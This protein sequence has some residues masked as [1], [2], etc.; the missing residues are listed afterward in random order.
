M[1]KAEIEFDGLRFEADLSRPIDISIPV[2]R[3]ESP[4]AFHLSAPDYKTVEAGSFVGN[5]SRGG[6]CNCEDIIFNPHGN[7]THT[8]CAGHISKE[9]IFINDVLK[10]FFFPALLLSISPE[11]G[12]ITA[13]KIKNAWWE[14]EIKYEAVI[15]RTLP[16]TIDK[17]S[18]NYS[19]TNPP[20]F[21]SDVMEFIN[22]K[23]IKHLLTDLPS[24]DKEDDGLLLA[25]HSFFGKPGKW[26]LDKT[27]TEMIFVPDEIQ[28]GF[29][30]L[31][32]QICSFESDASPSKPILYK[33]RLI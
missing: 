23:G 16:N 5:V 3:T 13:E 12:I 1:I 31:N 26:Q 25:H 17:R 33:S 30:L 24:L 4:N 6:S 9:K 21:A 14:D 10:K 7:G 8:E 2:G 22:T 29:Y 15:I 27:V 20:Y 11:N 18:R 19:G 28:D 32:L